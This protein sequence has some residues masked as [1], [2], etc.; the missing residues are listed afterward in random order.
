MHALLIIAH[1]S[2]R[3]ES[4]QEVRDLTRKVAGHAPHFG[5]VECAFLEL[6]DPD[7]V[8]GGSR[9]VKGGATSL[10][11]LPYFLVEG[12]HVASDVP[13]EVAKI[14]ALYPDLEI[15]ILPYFGAAD[16]V[17]NELVHQVSD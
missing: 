6:A 3:E 5:L 17:V 8:E 2:R 16:G 12:R 14:S 1:G 9:L 13:T 10:T 11:V 7:I 15:T 4:N